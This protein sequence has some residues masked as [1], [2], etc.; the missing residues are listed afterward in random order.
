MKYKWV[1]CL[2]GSVLIL[3]ACT[4]KQNKY[5]GLGNDIAITWELT[6]SSGYQSSAAFI[7]ENKGNTELDKSGWSLYFNQIGASPDKVQDSMLAYFEHINGDFFRLK[8]G[9]AFSLKPGEKIT[10]DYTCNGRII[11]E[12]HA[13]EGLYFVFDETGAGEL[14]VVVGNYVVLPFSDRTKLGSEDDEDGFSF[15]TPQSVFTANS[16]ITPL[17]TEKFGRILPT[18]VSFIAGNGEVELSATDHIYYQADCREEADYLSAALEKLTGVRITFSEGNK[19]GVNAILLKTAEM[20]IQG[21]D[22]EAYTLSISKSSGITITGAD[23]AGVFYGIQSLFSLIPP[24]TYKTRNTTFRIAEAEVRD[25]PRF[26][27]RGFHLDVAR[28]FSKKQT[29]LKLIDLLALYKI[30]TLHLHLTDDEGWRIEIPSLPELTEVGSRRGHT[31]NSKDLLLP[32]YGSGPFADAEKSSGTGYYSTQ[33]FIDILQYA[34]DRHIMVIPEINAPGHSRA[35]IRAMEFRYNRL[36]AEGNTQGALE[37]R[38]VDPNDSS[39]YSSAQNFNDNVICVALESVYRFY[40]TVVKDLKATYD[41]AGIPFTFI[42]TGGDEVPRGVWAKSPECSKL[43][44]LHPEI[45]NTQNLHGYFLG[46]LIEVLKQYDLTIGGWEEVAMLYTPDGW[47]PNPAYISQKVVPF[48]WNSLGSN[49]DLGYR[50]ANA[51]FPVILC[52]VN[53]F[54]FDLA[55]DPDPKEP[56]LYW[57]GFVDTRKAFDF[58]PYDVFKSNLRD[59]HGKPVDPATTY[60]GMERLKPEARK[61]ILGLQAELW[62]ETLKNPDMLEYDVLPKLLGFAERA[63][64]TAPS[65]ETIEDPV[66]RIKAVDAA[67]NEFVNKVGKYEFPRLNHMYGGFNYRIAPPGARI[68][69]ERLVANTDFPGLVI[70][71]TTDGSDPDI[72]S[73]VYSGPVKVSGTIKLKAFNDLGRASR[74]AEIK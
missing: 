37:Y 53:N 32:S 47:E 19:A 36:M 24:E 27:Y 67:W 52:N 21:T 35:A 62:S 39:V 58:M 13:P 1:S 60:K 17:T 54:Y 4:S 26:P 16:G 6:G 72:H 31:L 23:R 28:N 30:N 46:R 73:T 65:F 12:S 69:N 11:K 59:S 15:P 55:Y 68:D 29:V 44:Q 22:K 14:P 57:G 56:G 18:P 3:M 63:W 71:Y 64:S 38:L 10:L 8:P 42:H 49:L 41:Q 45:G 43:L 34:G 5:I 40:E 74:T 20:N 51:G 70:R 7:L 61:N 9:P 2:A 48:V 50:L 66:A 25:A 33:D